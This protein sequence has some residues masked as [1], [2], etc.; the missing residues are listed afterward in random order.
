MQATV[1][2]QLH[3]NN[4]VIIKRVMICIYKTFQRF[5]FKI[6]WVCNQFLYVC[7][8]VCMYVC[9]CVCTAMASL[10]ITTHSKMEEK[11]L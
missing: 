5:V 6:M 11:R 3:I 10:E 4:S 1:N 2:M 8:R 7:E 9:V